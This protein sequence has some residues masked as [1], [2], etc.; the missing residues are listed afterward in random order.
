MQTPICLTRLYP[1]FG[2]LH[3]GGFLWWIHEQGII[4][5]FFFHCYFN[6]K[7]NR[8]VGP[9]LCIGFIP[10]CKKHYDFLTLIIFET[11]DQCIF[12]EYIFHVDF[13]CSI[14][15]NH[16]SMHKLHFS[17]F[18]TF[19]CSILTKIKMKFPLRHNQLSQ[20]W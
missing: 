14:Y 16:Y 20:G 18:I 2:D 17:I 10:L 5:K 4:F 11:M 6:T 8:V 13:H 19:M 15:S 3:Y 12:Y 1:Y 9:C 7:C